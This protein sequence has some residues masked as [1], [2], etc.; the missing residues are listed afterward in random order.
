MKKGKK[1]VE[2]VYLITGDSGADPATLAAWIRSHWEI[3]KKLHWVRRHLPGRRVLVRTGNATRLM[4]SLRSL[5]I[6]LPRLDGHANIL[7]AD[8]NTG[9]A[10]PETDRTDVAVLGGVPVDRVLALAAALA[11]GLRHGRSQFHWLPVWLPNADRPGSNGPL[12][13]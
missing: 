4:A 2:V 12:M 6:S 9:R 7:P 10:E 3:E 11:C 8:A 13:R 5:A 1:T